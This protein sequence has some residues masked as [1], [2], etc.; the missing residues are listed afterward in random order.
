MALPSIYGQSLVFHLDDVKS[1][2][3]VMYLSKYEDHNRYLKPIK[4]YE[5]SKEFGET[6]DWKTKSLEKL[7]LATYLINGK[8]I[9]KL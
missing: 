5:N 8:N 6:L 2:K 4:I 7:S 9:L 1:L 3:I